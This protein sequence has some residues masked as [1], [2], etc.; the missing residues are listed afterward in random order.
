ML[1]YIIGWL[2][3]VFNPASSFFALIDDVSI[4]SKK[5]KIH[6]GAKIFNSKIDCYSYIT[7]G[8]SSVYAE[9]GKFCSIGHGS[10]I[11]LGHHTSD[12]LSTSP[13]FTE[14][15]NGTGHSWTNST[16]EYPFKK[17]IIGNDVW[18]GSRVMVMGGVKIGDGAVIAAGSIVTKDVPPY[19][20]VAGVP[21][22]LIKFRFEMDI[23]NKLLE[24]KWWDIQ[25]DELK[26]NINLF[27]IKNFTI[28]D[29]NKIQK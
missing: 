17:V 23:I 20:I 2:K 5:A 10:S 16:L 14:K 4:I 3:N 22:R 21:A 15:I 29:L 27:Q 8:S 19:A 18:I 28:E 11:G 13:I 7:K 25:Q 9:I 12:K 26:K 1:K 24:I 6:R